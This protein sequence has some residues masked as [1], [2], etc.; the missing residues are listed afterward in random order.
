MAVQ[1][2]LF[3][4]FFVGLVI[5]VFFTVVYICSITETLKSFIPKEST[6][7]I[8]HKNDDWAY[9][10]LNGEVIK[11]TRGQ[12]KGRDTILQT[13]IEIE[14]KVKSIEQYINWIFILTETNAI[15]TMLNDK[16]A[17]VNL[18]HPIK[19]MFKGCLITN[20]GVAYHIGELGVDRLHPTLELA[21]KA[22]IK[23][24]S[25]QEIKIDVMTGD[26]W[27]INNTKGI[28]ASRLH[29]AP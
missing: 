16:K 7:H 9:Y 28:M 27:M 23:L 13:K 3:L 10:L 21:S 26:I 18:G 17:K 11:L 25:F 1:L 8:R 29:V 19:D 6:Q 15:Y 24:S 14:E 22:E 12:G 4:F 5:G 2:I 20:N